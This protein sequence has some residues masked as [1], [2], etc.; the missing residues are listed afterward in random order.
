MLASV[1]KRTD[2][3][4]AEKIYRDVQ[5]S[6][7]AALAKPSSL[8]VEA[9]WRAALAMAE[10]GLGQRD[11][12]VAEAQHVVALVPEESDLLEGPTWQEYLA[13][14]YAMNG[15]AARALPLIEHVL[16]TNGSTLTSVLLKL[17]PVWDPIRQD[18]R[19]QKLVVANALAGQPEAAPKN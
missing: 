16:K 9:A 17:D 15:D 4:A 10:A 12:S 8:Y 11:K 14:V 19:F 6:A 5:A 7:T 2:S 1:E 13:M 3:A 18:A